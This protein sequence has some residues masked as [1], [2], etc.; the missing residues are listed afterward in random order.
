MTLKK[1]SNFTFI[2]LIFSIVFDPA[3]SILKLKNLSFFL[4]IILSIKD[5]NY[6]SIL[7]VLLFQVIFFITLAFQFLIPTTSI[8]YPYLIT[9]YKTFIL[10]FLLFHCEEKSSFFEIFYFSNLIVAF[11]CVLLWVIMFFIPGMESLLYGLFTIGFL[12]NSFGQCIFIARRS[13]IGITVFQ[14][15]YKT[16]PLAIICLAFSSYIFLEKRNTKYLLQSLLLFFYLFVSGTRMNIL[17]AICILIWSVMYHCIR[18]KKYVLVSAIFGLSCFSF[19][20]ILALLLSDKGDYSLNVKTLHIVSYNQLFSSNILRYLFV[21]DGPGAE[22]FTLGFNRMDS[23]TELSYY[24]LIRNYGLIFSIMILFVYLFPVINTNRKNKGL[25]L[26]MNIGY[27]LYLSVAGTNPFLFSS[28]GVIS[29]LIMAY[30]SKNT[31]Q[32]P[33]YQRKKENKTLRYLLKITH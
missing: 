22:F 14:V 2:I 3:N 10:F 5:L 21:G 32:F 23:V 31:L 18:Y 7:Q 33:E 20:V 27:L 12:K 28:T 19:I 24:D 1:V 25:G 30:I 16:S 6:K 13:F 15:F 26:S 11:F 4:F 17:C 9:T 29:F 8:D